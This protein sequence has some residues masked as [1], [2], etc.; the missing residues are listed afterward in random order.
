MR[1]LWGPQH[2]VVL[3]EHCGGPTWLPGLLGS[4]VAPLGTGPAAAV[5][6]PAVCKQGCVSCWGLVGDAHI[7]AE[8]GRQQGHPGS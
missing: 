5:P 4:S 1:S 8:A 7:V 2:Q 6:E 3:G